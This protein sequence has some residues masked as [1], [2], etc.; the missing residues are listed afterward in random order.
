MQTAHAHVKTRL[1]AIQTR[2]NFH[3]GFGAVQ[4]KGIS[5]TAI[6]TAHAAFAEL[7]SLAKILGL[8]VPYDPN[9]LD[10][11]AKLH[12]RAERKSYVYFDRMTNK[13][14]WKVGKSIDPLTRRDQLQTA[15]PDRIE[16][17]HK[18]EGGLPLERLI[19]RYLTKY[20]TKGRGGSEWFE[21]LSGVQIRALIR[22]IKAE[23]TEFLNTPLPRRKKGC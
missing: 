23:G 16:V 14:Q 3:P 8:S 4:V 5:D 7:K 2:H 15:N 6:L 10:P 9:G 20:Q 1:A 13:A 19:K 22:R 17:A 11:L 18:I 12:V 21:P